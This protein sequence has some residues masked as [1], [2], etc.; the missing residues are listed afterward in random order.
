MGASVWAY[1]ATDMKVDLARG[2]LISFSLDRIVVSDGLDTDVFHG[3]F[4][5]PQASLGGFLFGPFPT[6]PQPGDVPAL[7]FAQ[8]TGT[9]S[10]YEVLTPDG[11]PRYTVDLPDVPAN[12]AFQ[13]LA[14]RSTGAFQAFVFDG[15]D[16]FVG[17]SQDDR[18]IGYAG[19]DV[20]S[21]LNGNDDLRG[22]RG[23]DRLYGGNGDD[24]LRGG[25]DRD[26]IFGGDGDD[27]LSG[28]H[29]IDTLQGQDGDDRLLGGTSRDY[30]N[31]G[32]GD[33]TFQ[34]KSIADSRPGSST[35]D[36]LQDFR[37]GDDLIDLHLIDANATK[38]GNQAFVFIGAAAFTDTPG[39]L[40]Y[41][42]HTHLLQGDTTG[43]GAADF[44]VNLTNKALIGIDDLI[45]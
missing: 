12:S 15:D 42:S 32:D 26:W 37:P 44:E 41:D 9:L 30:L 33:D 43:D 22:G 38:S 14:F 3:S 39:Q 18:L 8:V 23:S 11:Q 19:D 4:G 36:Q 7:L 16:N 10:G 20:L 2:F 5:I 31:G 21:G 17:S 45:L 6:I 28:G 24:V 34:F 1:R 13:A 40:R 25:H 29:G 27:V 35:R